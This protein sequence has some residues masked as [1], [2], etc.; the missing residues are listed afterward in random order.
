MIFVCVLTDAISSLSLVHEQPEANLLKR[1]PRSVKKDRLADWRLL[2]HAYMFVGTPLTI[3]SCAMG[4]WW[5]SRAGIPFSD[6]WLLFQQL[7]IGKKSTQNLFLFPAMATSLLIAVFLSYVPAFEKVFLTRGVSVEHYFLPMAFGVGMLMLEET[8][9]LL[10]RQ[11]PR[12]FV[13]WLAW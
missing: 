6:M 9:K 10:V 3:I 7:P 8:R 12:S 1:K 11:Y 4:F 5:M 2:F 13:A